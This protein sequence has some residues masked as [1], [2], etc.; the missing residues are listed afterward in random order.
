MTTSLAGSEPSDTI[1][2]VLPNERI[3]R[4]RK[5]LIDSQSRQQL[6]T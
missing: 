3:N 1:D 4:E 2:M 5:H 6:N